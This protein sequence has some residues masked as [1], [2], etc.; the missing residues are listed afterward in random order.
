MGIWT[1][2]SISATCLSKDAEMP[3]FLT[4]QTSIDPYKA[5]VRIAVILLQQMKLKLI[6]D[7]EVIQNLG[8]DLR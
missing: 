3:C 6:T 2:F 4:Q 8:V 5:A 1:V 7:V